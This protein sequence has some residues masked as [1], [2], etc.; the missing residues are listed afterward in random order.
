MQMDRTAQIVT[1]MAQN[2]N[3]ADLVLFRAGSDIEL[4]EYYE[5]TKR[6]LAANMP[7]LALIMLE[8]GSIHWPACAIGDEFWRAM[9]VDGWNTIGTQKAMEKLCAIIE[10]NLREEALRRADIGE[11]PAS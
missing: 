1:W 2:P 7:E 5:V 9:A 3:D 6:L 10:A 4:G 8:A 11:K